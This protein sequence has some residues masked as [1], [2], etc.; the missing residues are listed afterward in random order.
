MV[1]CRPT[2]ERTV[3][4]VSIG[5]SWLKSEDTGKAELVRLI[6]PSAAATRAVRA[7]M[8]AANFIILL[9]LPLI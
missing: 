6:E 1:L 9:F 5:A 8:P 7:M 4:G 2:V 3:P